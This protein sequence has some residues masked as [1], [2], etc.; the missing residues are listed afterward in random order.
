MSAKLINLVHHVLSLRGDCLSTGVRRSSSLGAILASGDEGDDPRF[1]LK[2]PE[3]DFKW[4]EQIKGRSLIMRSDS[5]DLPPVLCEAVL[6]CGDDAY[7]CSGP[8]QSPKD[9]A[10]FLTNESSW[11]HPL[12]F[13]ADVSEHSGGDIEID[14]YGLLIR[15][16]DDEGFIACSL[17]RS[18]HVACAPG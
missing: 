5:R 13:V 12:A 10:R 11:V 18:V 7:W 2:S 1:A 4:F 8:V 17:R 3:Q 6:R 9:A 16:Y 15:A 14:I